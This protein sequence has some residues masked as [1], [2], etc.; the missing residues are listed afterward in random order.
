MSGARQSA[1]AALLLI[2]MPCLAQGN[3]TIVMRP[4][5]AHQLAG[6]VTVWQS[7]QPSGKVHVEE[8]DSSWE[9][10]LAS[11]M[12]DD[13]GRF[14]LTPTAKGSVHYLRIYAPGYDI[15]EYT[16]RLSRFAKT[17]LRLE[18]HVGT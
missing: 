11:T 16:V 13:Q 15:S 7:E 1:L 3:E 2:A 18:L 8:C 4:V 9:H 10:V 17:E 14:H 12:T 5:K 6:I